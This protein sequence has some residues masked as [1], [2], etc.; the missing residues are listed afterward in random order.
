MFLSWFLFLVSG[1]NKMKPILKWAGG[2]RQISN[3]ILPHIPEIKGTYFEPFF[4]GGAIFFD[5]SPN[6]AVLN[7]I[8]AELVNLYD[9]FFD[10]Q[11]LEEL[12][13]LLRIHEENHSKEFFYQIRELDRSSNY[14]ETSPVV[15]AARVLYL[16]KACFNGLYRV[17]SNGYFNVPFNNSK[18]VNLCDELN[19]NE[20]A[21]FFQNNSITFSSLDFEE[22]VKKAKKNDF[23][24]FD[25]PYDFI[26]EK[27]SF[28][29]YAKES[30]GAGEQKRLSYIC[31]ELDK[32]GVK[33]LLSN[34]N[35]PYIN[36]IYK[37][38]TIQVIQA[39][40]MI[41]S[42]ADQRGFVDEVLIR[43]Y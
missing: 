28:T 37:N 30:F 22:V 8:N 33:W 20:I 27:Q 25:P 31:S 40:R 2:K 24:Y 5:L 18:K 32:K 13:K 3:L 10:N 12:V 17:N 9:V 34:H 42:K 26:R 19:F 16:N 4:G 14:L 11:K 43:N 38:F 29:T 7:D 23:V 1:E 36:N 15:R 41:N 6:K 21:K 39:K 35:T